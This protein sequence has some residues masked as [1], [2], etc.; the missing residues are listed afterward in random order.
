MYKKIFIFALILTLLCGLFIACQSSGD[1]SKDENKPANDISPTD[2][3]DKPGPKVYSDGLEGFD[4]GGYTVRMLTGY[5]TFGQTNTLDVEEETG[6]TLNDAI[7]KRNRKLEERFNVTLTE[8]GEPDVWNLTGMVQRSVRAESDDY[9]MV[10]MI[11][12]EAFSLVCSGNYFYPMEQ[13]PHVNLDN[14]WW[15]QNARRMMSIGGRMFFT[16]GDE[17]VPYFEYMCLM[18]FNKDMLKDYALDDPYNLVRNGKWTIDK[19]YEMAKKV[20][21]DLNSDGVY[22]DNDRLGIIGTSS[23]Y[24]PSFWIS[25]NILFI[26]KDE[27]D[28][29]YFNVPGNQKMFTIMEK[30][31]DYDQQNVMLNVTRG[32]TKYTQDGNI[33]ASTKIFAEGEILFANSSVKMLADLR[34][35]EVDLGVLPYPKLSEVPAGTDY[36]TRITSAMPLV[37]PVTNPDPERASV[38]L[39]AFSCESKNIVIPAYYNIVLKNKA[40]RDIESEEMLDMMY[41]NRYLDLGDTLFMEAV[42]DPYSDLYTKNLNTYA[43]LTEKIEANVQRQIDKAVDTYGQ[44]E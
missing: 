18:V 32:R 29:P 24:Y 14:P 27:N 3:T 22:D 10:L 20:V 44:I 9:D 21:T 6:D 7:Y 30:L 26:E 39:E 41:N 12:R 17:S 43:S 1:N 34:S 35:S 37:I 13:L 36:G 33:I 16:Y 25:E 40:M 11:D 38:I 4:F 28:I 23:Y 2:E 31:Y 19:M 5:G 15:D 8:I 42:R